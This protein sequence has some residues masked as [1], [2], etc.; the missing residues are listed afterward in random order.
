MDDQSLIQLVFSPIGFAIWCM[1]I[2]AFL[3]AIKEE[4]IESRKAQDAANERLINHIAAL[5]VDLNEL[6]TITSYI[7]VQQKRY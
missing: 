1:A 6:K 5:N 3:W 4:M 2:V 7:Q